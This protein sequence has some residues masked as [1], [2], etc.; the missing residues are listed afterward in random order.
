[1]RSGAHVQ[2]SVLCLAARFTF[3]SWVV[4][5]AVMARRGG[6]RETAVLADKAHV[7]RAG[8][9]RVHFDVPSATAIDS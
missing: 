1:M 8:S 3:L 6:V 7:A 2:W 5:R 4:L 9:P